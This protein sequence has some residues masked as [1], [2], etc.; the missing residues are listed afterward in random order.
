MLTTI[1]LSWV[2]STVLS[3]PLL[4]EFGPQIDRDT[5]RLTGRLFSVV[6]PKANNKANNAVRPF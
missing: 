1:S 4:A 2:Y 6:A 3:L 5:G